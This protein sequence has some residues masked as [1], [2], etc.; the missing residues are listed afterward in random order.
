MLQQTSSPGIYLFIL[1]KPAIFCDT[2]PHKN[3]TNDLHRR[4]LPEMQWGYNEWCSWFRRQYL[5]LPFLFL[6]MGNAVNR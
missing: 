4:F 6:W 1:G 5:L 3:L 2:C